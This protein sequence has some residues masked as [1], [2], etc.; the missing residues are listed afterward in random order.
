MILWAICGVISIAGSFT[1]SELGA[2]ILQNGGE[3]AYLKKAY[4]KPK[5]FFSYLFSFTFI[6]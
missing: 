1:Y 6:V 2:S 5:D 3:I 4:P